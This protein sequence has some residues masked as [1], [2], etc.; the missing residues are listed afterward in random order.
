MSAVTVQ[1][2]MI[3][4]GGDVVELPRSVGD[5]AVF[6]D[7][8]GTLL[9][10]AE[11]P[12]AIVVPAR[13][14]GDLERVRD[15]ASGALALVSGRTIEAIDRMFAPTRLTTIGLHGG[16]VRE[17]DGRLVVMPAPQILAEL[18]PSLL[19]LAR[20]FPGALLE[21]KG[22]SIAVHF[23]RT[24][25]A[26][27]EI[28]KAVE[29]MAASAGGEIFVQKGKK[30]V[31]LRPSGSSKGSAVGAMMQVSPFAGRKPLA[32]GDDVTDEAMFST[33]NALGGTTIRVGP[34]DRSTKA[35][36]RIDDPAAL[37][38]W[39]ASLT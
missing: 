33:V 32:V 13:L 15:A 28:E 1:H 24:P 30:V 6:L 35:R 19:A 31:E 4:P 25:A 26:E 8:D 14:P 37:R 39:L 36:F 18:R 2:A 7:V 20:R 27:Q 29:A 23:R 34:P 9:D 5:L 22:R 38:E 12:D 10:I 3:G 16:E 17:P 11:T 21:D